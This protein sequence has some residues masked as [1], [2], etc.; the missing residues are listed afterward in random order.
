M[1]KDH[2]IERTHPATAEEI[3]DLWT[4]TDGIESWWAPD[5]F[6]TQVETLD[7]EPDGELVYTMTATGPEQVEFMRGAGLPLTNRSRKRFTEID[8]PRR[9]AYYS[10]VDFVPDVAPYEQLTVVELEPTS[11]D[12]TVTMTVEPMHD[13]EWTQRLLAG[14]A[15]E[16]DNLGRLIEKRRA[17]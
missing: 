13:D 16:L 6:S 2:R 4:T 10:L 3:W 1:P 15:N 9:L 5:G 7:L 12:V 14:R 17:G 11:S 8:R